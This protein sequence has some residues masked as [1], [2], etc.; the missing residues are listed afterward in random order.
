M[1]FLKQIFTLF[2]LTLIMS[3]ASAQVIGGM[4]FKLEKLYMDEK[5]E[6]VAYK[7]ISMIENDKYKKD[8]EIYLYIAMAWYEISQM[9]DEEMKEEYPKA[10][11]DAF[12]YAAKFVKKDRDGVW[13]TDNAD[14]FEEL[15]KAGIAEANQWIG[16]PKKM[17]N[18]VSSYKYMTKAI[19]DDWNLLFY[20]GVLEYMNRNVG[21]AER[22][23]ALAMT[24]LIKLYEDPKYRASKASKPVLEG[25]MIE[26]SDIM[27][28][29]NY[30]DSAK[31]TINWAIQFFPESEKVAAKAAALK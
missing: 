12:K 30:A 29:Q 10:L 1:A 23:I 18:A 7:G 17:R 22:D 24:N 25:G 19:P 15:K 28:E 6:D 13:Y 5:Y 31:K 20:K 4:N 14:F 9:N 8:P 3:S 27:M 21:Q 2:S 26:W 16:D 11:R